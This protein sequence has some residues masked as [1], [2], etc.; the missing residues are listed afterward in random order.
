MPLGPDVNRIVPFLLLLM[1]CIAPSLTRANLEGFDRDLDGVSDEIDNCA[2]APNPDQRDRDGNGLGDLCDFKEFGSTPSALISLV[3]DAQRLDDADG[4]ARCANATVACPDIISI[5]ATFD[6]QNLYF[7][8]IFAEGSFEIDDYRLAILLDLDQDPGTGSS[9]IVCGGSYAGIDL[10]LRS[11][12][13]APS[14][15][16]GTLGIAKFF[17]PST[18][19]IDSVPIDFGENALEIVIPA[20]RLRGDGIVDYGLFI[21]DS[22]KDGFVNNCDAAPNQGF[23]ASVPVRQVMIDIKPRN[24]LNRINPMSRGVIPVAILGSESFDVVEVDR[25]TLAFAPGSAPPAHRTG[26]HFRN[27]NDDGVGDLVTHYRTEESAVAFGDTQAC[28]RGQL[29]DGTR[30]EGCDSIQAVPLCGLGF[31]LVF[32]LP[33]LILFARRRPHWL[34]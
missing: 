4:D 17:P 15:S 11:D 32:L 14:A 1:L 24:D 34:H 19:L 22:R 13:N 21:L 30:F 16:F 6:R 25:T 26:G 33:P 23:V 27:A 8:V 2:I 28:V 18:G 9:G 29:F 7:S 10:D 5:E 3:S 20:S 12:T 31:E